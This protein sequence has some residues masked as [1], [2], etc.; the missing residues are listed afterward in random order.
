MGLLAA[1]RIVAGIG[2][3]PVRRPGRRHDRGREN[4]AGLGVKG[5]EE[6]RLGLVMELIEV[7]ARA[8][9]AFGHADFSPIGRAI[10][11]AFETL[12]VY[13]GFDQE[14]GMVVVLL[15][16]IAETFE[17]EAQEVGG[18]IG[19]LAL[20]REQREPSITGEQMTPGVA[21]SRR[22]ADP[23]F[24][25]AQMES[26]AGPAEQ[27]DP[28]AVLF[29]DVAKGLADHTMLLEVMMLADQ[30]VPARFFLR[31]DQLH[32]DL[33]VGNFSE[34]LAYWMLRTG[35]TCRLWWTNHDGNLAVA[36][37]F[38]Q[39]KASNAQVPMAYTTNRRSRGCLGRA[40]ILPLARGRLGAEGSRVEGVAEVDDGLMDCW[41]SG[42]MDC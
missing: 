23:S 21:L 18:Q 42:L 1:Q 36:E 2:L 22:P 7:D 19:R 26:G 27:G 16:I 13:V 11:G 17:V 39:L 14:Q 6:D 34:Y 31:A 10:T 9:E 32:R 38:V 20:G 4:L 29:G 35:Y 3:A 24:P 25:R 33:L 40:G 28:P 30:F 37:C 41:I 5:I 12:G 15:P 8:A